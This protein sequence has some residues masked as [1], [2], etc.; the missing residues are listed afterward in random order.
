MNTT[1]Q[2]ELKKKRPFDSLEQETV[3]NLFRTADQFQLR[4]ERLF[5]QHGLTHSQYNVLRILRGEG[6]PLPI[7]EVAARTITVV[8]GITGL[9]DRLEKA[10]L[11]TRRRCVKD[12]RVIYVEITPRGVELLSQ[13]DAPLTALQAQLFAHMPPTRLKQLCQLLEEA[14]RPLVESPAASHNV[15]GDKS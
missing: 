11:L 7:L 13:I 1:L 9:I 6:G 12:R 5:R 8:P 15:P 2:T 10:G 4:F 14:R 3:L